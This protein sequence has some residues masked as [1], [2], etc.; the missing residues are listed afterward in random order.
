MPGP[1]ARLHRV[2]RTARPGASAAPQPCRIRR[3]P[4]RRLPRPSGAD[5]R[6]RAQAGGGPPLL[7]GPYR[8]HII[9]AQDLEAVFGPDRDVLAI[10]LGDDADPG[11][12]S[13]IF[14][15]PVLQ[16]GIVAGSAPTAAAVSLPLLDAVF[17]CLSQAPGLAGR[18]A[19]PPGVRHARCTRR[20]PKLMCLTYVIHLIIPDAT[21]TALSGT[22]SRPHGPSS[23]P[24]TACAGTSGSPG[25]KAGN[26][27]LVRNFRRLREAAAAAGRDLVCVQ[28]SSPH[29]PSVSGVAPAGSCLDHSC[30]P[31]TQLRSCSANWS[32]SLAEPMSI[33]S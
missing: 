5:G 7:S 31:T 27:R 23:W 32:T 15:R 1:P 29:R 20:L 14:G 26:S 21:R 19:T 28:R 3:G 12:G 17:H 9:D 33:A 30:E 18:Q 22:A 8:G 13:R 2:R 25:R 11:H 24:G 10:Y 16:G 4:E 6:G